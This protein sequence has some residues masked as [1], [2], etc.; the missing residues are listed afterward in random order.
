MIFS[1]RT[2]QP[3]PRESLV[4]A[5]RT[6]VY[7][8]HRK[9]GNIVE[10]AGFD[11]SVWFEGIIPEC[12]SVRNN[13]GIFDVSHM[14]RVLAEGKGAES[15]LNQLTTNDVSKLA[16]GRGQYSL[17]CN[18]KGGIMDD[19]T[20]FRTGSM[21]YLVVYN[22]GN[23]D[24]NWNWLLKNRPR[25][26][27]TLSDVSDNVAMFAVQGPRA[28]VV[29]W[30]VSGVKLEEVEKYGTRDVKVAGVPCLLTR[31]GYT[32]EDGFEIY[33]WNTSVK[34]PSNAVKIWEKL[35]SGGR[36]LGICP[37]GL[38]AR[39]VLRLEAG[40]CLYGNDIDENIS[41]VEAKLNWVVHLEKPDFVGKNGIIDL[42][43]KGPS[44][45]RVG[46]RMKEKGIPRQ[47]QDILADAEAVGKVSSGT[48]SPTLST[49]IGM[50]YVPPSLA[51]AGETFSVG[52]RDRR[53][54]AEVVK[55]PFY[56]RRSESQV[57]VFGEEMGLK[58]FRK[59]YSS[60]SQPKVATATH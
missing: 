18:P 25:N 29:L 12:H 38:G 1:T 20:I 15:F 53:V 42:K 28:G 50:G 2:E 27:V 39:D 31:S 52:I 56:Q 7:E 60:S 11:L 16:V 48:F 22:A 43:E 37:I 35:L 40:M 10:Y 47:S 51:A 19:L 57:V 26:D 49:G 14:G 36:E 23:R 55:L 9:H 32:G 54:R 34:E 44:R 33:V 4:L 24:K 59:Q 21:R 8:Y 5:R 58:D 46:F 41:P 30:N 17:L 45:V 3:I 13:C 6:H